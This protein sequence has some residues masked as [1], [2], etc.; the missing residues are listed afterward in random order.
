MASLI[1]ENG[2]LFGSSRS[3]AYDVSDFSVTTEEGQK[4]KF[5]KLLET[6]WDSRMVEGIFRYELGDLETRILPGKY[7]FVA[8]LNVKRA[9]QRRKPQFISTISMPFNP[10]IFNF[11]K[12]RK[13]EILFELVPLH[14]ESTARD[15]FNS[16]DGKISSHL[17]IINVSPLEY[18]N[19]LLVPNINQFLPQILTHES[20]QLALETV[21][22]SHNPALR[23]GFNSLG[24]YASVNH[25]HF[26]MY[27]LHHRL[28][29]E[30]ADVQHFAGDCFELIDFPAEG[31]AFQLLDKN[32]IKTVRSIMKLSC[33]FVEKEIAHNIFITRGRCFLE[34]SNSSNP[35]ESKY[36][37]VRIFMWARKSSFGAKD[38]EAFNPALCE[39][40]G[41]LPV[42]NEASFSVITEEQAA[43]V[44]KEACHEV[45]QNVRNDVKQLF[46]IAT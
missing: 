15:T 27:Y 20:V 6:L 33:L 31:F 26:H 44:L 36:D 35:I 45:F 24:A 3:I 43:A 4:S 40:A 13:E 41:H 14:W 22:L 9:Q 16:E 8:Q 29:L 10:E 11:L 1:V 37:A 21:L 42:K 28:Y 17:I 19:S 18:C 32:V 2:N 38:D 12:V 7:G 34:C 46:S 30:N 25:Q 5:D 23:L 39:L